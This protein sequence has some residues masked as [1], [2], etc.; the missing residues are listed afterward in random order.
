MTSA[1]A[2]LPAGYVI[3][4]FDA[5]KP[6]SAGVDMDTYVVPIIILDDLNAYGPPVPNVN[7]AGAM[8]QPGYRKI[9]EFCQTVR[10]ELRAGGQAIT[11]GGL[12]ATS[13][14]PAISYAWMTVNGTTYRAGRLAFQVQQ[15]RSRQQQP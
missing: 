8:E 13:T 9:L 6:Y 5:V 15:R 2:T 4:M 11:Q 3:P 10:G 14:I 1:P 12:A 7:V